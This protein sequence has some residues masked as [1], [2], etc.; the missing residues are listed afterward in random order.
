MTS[1]DLK[2]NKMIDSIYQLVN[3]LG[4]LKEA[5]EHLKTQEMCNEAVQMEPYSLAFVPDH[6]KTQGM[7][8]KAVCMEPLLLK[9]VPDYLKTLYFV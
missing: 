2:S 1:P 6:F 5:P 3:V 9:Y 4:L 7:C 8:N